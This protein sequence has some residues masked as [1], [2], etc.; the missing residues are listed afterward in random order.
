MLKEH[1]VLYKRVMIFSDLCIVLATFFLGFLLKNN[2]TH[3]YDEL[4]IYIVVVPTMLIT[5]GIL[6]YYFGM[7]DSFRIK[8]ISDVLF[9][10]IET[11][12]VGIGFFG[13]FLF[14]TKI[15]S[16]SRLQIGYSFLLAALFISIEKILLIKYFRYQR[17]KGINIR[18]F[19]IVGTGKRAQ[20]FINLINK[21]AEWGIKAIGLIDDDTS[22]VSAGTMYGYKIL[23]TIDDIP[24]IIHN[25]VVDEVLFVVPRSW[26]NK[27]EKI[28]SYVCEVEGIKVS[29]AI[30]L[31]EHHLSKAKYSYLDTLPLLT[32]DSTPDEL[33]Q[34]LIKRLFD[35][36]SS[37]IAILILSPVFLITAIII[38]ASSKGPIFFRQKRCSLSGRRF[39]LYKFRTMVVDAE[40]KLEELLA[41]NEMQGPVFKMENDPRLTKAGKFLRKFSIDE[42]PQFWNVFRGD[43]SLVG[44]RPPLPA[45]VDKY[46]PWQRRRL[47]MRPGITCLWQARGRNK[48]NDFDEWME[49]DLEYIDNW[50]L[51]FDFK[52]LLKTVPVVLFGIGAK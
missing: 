22:R 31:F 37:I 29:V 20:D 15:H 41:Y 9:I 38:K 27:I 24:N 13:S 48:I 14:I 26:L 51:W 6:L 11:T 23:G 28:I 35:F 49:L 43:M 17:K 47:S 4:D 19:L 52:I 36:F 8:H 10:V 40:S 33:I 18:N 5:W 25:H 30:D 42:L 39:T 7:Y 2:V 44:P 32:F 45:E 12:F 50:S 34:L 16:I 3:F 1:H 46:E 21:H